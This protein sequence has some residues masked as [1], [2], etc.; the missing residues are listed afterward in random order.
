MMLGDKLPRFRGD[1]KVEPK[2]DSK[3]LFEVTDISAGKHF[4]LYDFEL[5][6]ARMM[7]GKRTVQQ[8][9]ESSTRL[10]IPVTLEGLEKFVRQLRAYGFVEDGSELTNIG[11]AQSF[12]PREEWDPALRDLFTSALVKLRQNRF[13]EAREYLEAMLAVDKDN[14]E[15]QKVIAEIAER[16]KNAPAAAQQ[17]PLAQARGETQVAERPAK[18]GPLAKVP[19]WGFAVAGGVLAL[20]VLLIP[21]PRSLAAS[22]VLEAGPGA[23]VTAPRDAV[24]KEPGTADGKWVDSGATLVKLDTAER[25]AT[26]KKLETELAD[27]TNKL[28]I[29]QKLAKKKKAKAAVIDRARELQAR[30]DAH[31]AELEKVRL[32]TASWLIT[33][34]VAG[35]VSELKAVPGTKLA[36]GEAVA[37]IVDPRMLKVTVTVEAKAS[38]AVQA[39]QRVVATV[40]GHA[41]DVELKSIEGG[42]A[43]GE[44]PNPDRVFA[45]GDRGSGAIKVGAKSLL[46]RLF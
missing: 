32:D 18:P 19:G 4:T 40:N 6:M 36:A 22:V 27:E 14:A 1:L 25:E 8:V 2:T 3:G 44:L 5:S 20:V 21:L 39:G 46:G 16:E 9:L 13:A 28:A 12:E 30:V 41:V 34:N 35:L 31:R 43:K 23:P 37:R 11:A 45:P 38:A 29:A 24:V 7:D 10:A 26:L 33:S 15:A 17:P 42:V